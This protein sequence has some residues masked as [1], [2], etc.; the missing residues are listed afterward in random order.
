M[1]ISTLGDTAPKPE[2]PVFEEVRIENT[3]LCGF[4]CQFCP[5]E[6]MTRPKGIQSINDF[7][8]VLDRVEEYAGVYAGQVHL[9][10][11]GEPLLDPNLPTKTRLLTARWPNA[12]PWIITTL[13]YMF[14]PDYLRELVEAGMRQIIVSFYGADSDSYRRLTGVD[15]FHQAYQ[16]LSLLAGLK[17]KYGKQLAI[18]VQS[19]LTGLSSTIEQPAKQEFNRRCAE[20]GLEVV[21]FQLHNYGNGRNYEQGPGMLCDRA[22]RRHLFQVTWDLKVIPCCMDYDGALVLGDLRTNSISDILSNPGSIGFLANHRSG[23]AGAY[24]ACR[25]CSMRTLPLLEPLN[26]SHQR[27]TTAPSAS[28]PAH[29]SSGDD[30]EHKPERD[31]HRNIGDVCHASSP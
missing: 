19:S 5:R 1:K 31:V 11:Y 21:S 25:N 17:T 22:I 14:P 3:N 24:A 8:L 23:K 2:L 20:L 10:G 6:K 18:R 7:R 13:G 29:K 30:A 4:K 15:R 12:L 28:E 16:N 27:F 9:H 26:E